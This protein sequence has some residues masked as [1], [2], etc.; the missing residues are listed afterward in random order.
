MAEPAAPAWPVEECSSCHARIIWAV[1]RR[2]LTMP[3]DAEPVAKGGNVSL[4]WRGSELKPLAR[5]L[6]V[7]QQFG[8]KQLWQS[9]FVTC[10]N[11]ARHRH[12]GRRGGRH[13]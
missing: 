4:E 6:S 3:V 8:R 7:A 11:A 9:H 12:A 5:V 1:T 10:P 2:A 13:G